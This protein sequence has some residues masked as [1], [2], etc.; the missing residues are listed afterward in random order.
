[1][2]QRTK[3]QAKVKLDAADLAQFKE[4]TNKK[5][6]R[7][8]N[9][10]AQVEKAVENIE[11]KFK[12][13]EAIYQ[14]HYEIFLM[15]NKKLNELKESQQSI[16]ENLENEKKD[17]QNELTN[18]Q[19]EYLDSFNLLNYTLRQIETLQKNILQKQV[20]R[21]ALLKDIEKYKKSIEDLE[22]VRDLVE[23]K[24]NNATNL[25]T[26]LKSELAIAKKRWALMEE[27]DWK[28]LQE[29]REERKE[30]RTKL[31]SALM[32]NDNR[33][34]EYK[35]LQGTYLDTKSKLADIY[36]D[37]L[38]TEDRIKDYLQLSA[39]QTRMHKALVDYSRQRGLYSQAELA[40]FQ[41]VSRENA[42]KI[43]A[44][45]GM[46]HKLELHTGI[47]DVPR[48]PENGGEGALNVWRP[49]PS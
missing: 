38:K 49:N 35:Q 46:L 48:D 41:A 3:L 6:E 29:R 30:V 37:R 27:K 1:M 28:L 9:K 21:T 15:L 2:N 17:L 4:S 47:R 16:S 32:E 13:L 34:A 5:K 44:V 31:A 23:F 36:Y 19:K 22:P 24:H 42:Q 14:N 18:D 39:L 7:A 45:Q 25:I 40:T 10:V 20:L 26:N 11:T 8:S 43:I 33:T 12:E